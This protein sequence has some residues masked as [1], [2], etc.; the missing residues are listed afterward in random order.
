M[1]FGVRQRGNQL[2]ALNTQSLQLRQ[3]WLAVINYMMRAQLLGPLGTFFAGS[4]AY[5]GQLGQLACQLNQN[6]TDATGGA[7]HQ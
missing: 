4:R 5:N 7:N 6:R 2:H 3:H 1:V